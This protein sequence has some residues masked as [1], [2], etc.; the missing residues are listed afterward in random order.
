MATE[1]YPIDYWKPLLP[2]LSRLGIEFDQRMQQAWEMCASPMVSEVGILTALLK[3]GTVGLECLPAEWRRVGARAGW[4]GIFAGCDFPVLGGSCTRVVPEQ[5]EIAA[6][7]DFPY[8]MRAVD[9]AGDQ[10][11]I[12]CHHFCR[13]ISD[14]L[15]KRW[16]A[17]VSSGPPLALT[18][19]AMCI[20]K[21]GLP[22]RS[23]AHDARL[24]SVLDTMG[25]LPT[26]ADDFQYLLSLE[27]NKLVFRTVSSACDFPMRTPTGQ[28]G[29]RA[30]LTHLRD[31]FGMFTVEEVRELEELLR[32]KHS[33]EA[34][35]QAF[36]ERH[37]HFLRRLDY[38]EVYPHVYLAREDEGPLVPDFILTNPE[39]QRAMVLELKPPA[40]KLIRRARNRDRFAAAIQ[41]ARA[42]LLAY[43]D[44][45]REKANRRK[46]SGV[47]GMEI[48]EPRLGVVIGRSSDFECGL[49]RQELAA[50]EPDL[51]LWT[52]DDIV[53]EAKRKMLVTR[54][55]AGS[56][57]RSPQEDV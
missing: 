7:T 46:L 49:D 26:T 55:S 27:D 38:R 10:K 52:Y 13:A 48:L 39:V 53:A 47:L 31:R 33:A 12:S 28:A 50:R 56:R 19:L 51:V 1:R 4:A 21:E 18:W 16:E 24:R 30:F 22:F 40:A 20:E 23:P 3:L 14:V 32:S 6:H 17:P 35:F 44:W 8:W 37:P 15:L 42:Q 43:R 25:R 29:S 54:W 11:T 9:L 45:F 41:E 2:Q 57:S 34:D 36:F 5:A